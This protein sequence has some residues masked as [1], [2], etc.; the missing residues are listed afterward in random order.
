MAKEVT[1]VEGRIARIASRQKGIATFAELRAA[2]VSGAEIHHRAEVG[3]LIRVYRGVYRVGHWAPSTEAAYL[4]AVKAAGE[5]AVLAGL[6]A[7][8]LYGLVRGDPPPP[9]VATP[10]RRRIPGLRTKRRRMHPLDRTVFRGIPVLPVPAVLVDIAPDLDDGAL[11][12]AC[13][14]AG[15]RYRT[16][17]SHVQAVLDRR[18]NSPSAGKLKRVMTGE[19]PVSLSKLESGFLDVLREAGLPLPVTNRLAG[20]KRVDCRWPGRPL[21]VELDSYRFHNTRYAWE[22]DLRREREAHEREEAFRRY[23]WADVFEDSTY[24]LGEL[25]GFLS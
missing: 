13:H 8:H 20:T 2:D 7:A 21:T 22:Q 14:E 24:M 12:R 16:T 25:R 5:G 17:P 19:T 23:T 11:A 4:A 10:A 6:A 15:V 9:Q 18:P 3:L 1:T